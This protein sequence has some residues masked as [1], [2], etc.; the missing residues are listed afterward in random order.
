[1]RAWL[2]LPPVARPSSA[3]S[4]TPDRAALADL[5]GGGAQ[6]PEKTAPAKAEPRR[7]TLYRPLWPVMELVIW[8]V[9]CWRYA[10]GGLM[11]AGPPLGYD[12]P[13]VR[14]LADGAGVNW[15]RE[16]LILL[17]AAEAEQTAHLQ[18]QWMRAQKR[19]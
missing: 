9:G 6:T 15:D 4:L 19:K 1:V 18:D 13:Q 10:P 8:S 14:A 17:K 7:V 2:G 16:N 5:A 12:W 11:G 3:G